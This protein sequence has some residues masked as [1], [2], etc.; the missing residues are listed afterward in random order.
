MEIKGTM[1]MSVLKMKPPEKEKEKLLRKELEK[2]KKKGKQNFSA[3]D[4]GHKHMIQI[5]A[6]IVLTT[7]KD[8]N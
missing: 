2:L 6:P 1:H 5:L 4:V 3:I 7:S 8:Q